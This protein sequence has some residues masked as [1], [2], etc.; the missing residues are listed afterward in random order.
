M[1]EHSDFEPLTLIVSNT[2]GNSTS[3]VESWYLDL[4]C[5]NHMTYHKEWLINFDSTKKS[6]VKFVDDSKVE[7]VE[8]VVIL[9]KND[10]KTMT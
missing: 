8:D 6:K 7:G 1:Q 9:R 4:G 5:S 10:S 2:T 3:K